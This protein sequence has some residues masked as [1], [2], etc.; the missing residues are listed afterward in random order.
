MLEKKLEL[1]GSSSS[2]L[3][4]ASCCRR[5][6]YT[7][8]NLTVLAF[9]EGGKPEEN[10]YMYSADEKQQKSEPTQLGHIDEKQVL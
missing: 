2:S 9:V 5:H 7:I 4:S 6:L 8:N 3:A 1:N 10:P